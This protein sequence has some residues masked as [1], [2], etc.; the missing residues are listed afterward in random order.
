MIKARNDKGVWVPKPI[1]VTSFDLSSDLDDMTTKFAEHF[2]DSWA[3]RKVC[4][5]ALKISYMTL[6]S[7][8]EA[9]YYHFGLG[10]FF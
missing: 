1:D 9:F 5:Q 6:S 4:V 3:A 2:H 10:L 8:P 7:S